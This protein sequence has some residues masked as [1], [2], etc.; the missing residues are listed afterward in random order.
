MARNITCPACSRKVSLNALGALDINNEPVME[1]HLCG[2]RRQCSGSF[3]SVAAMVSVPDR[4][5]PACGTRDKNWSAKH[6]PEA[7]VL[8]RRLARNQM[9]GSAHPNRG[10]ILYTHNCNAH[11]DTR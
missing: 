3:K 9:V 2:D 5:C 1:F 4:D 11:G 7:E 10:H 6:K 8:L